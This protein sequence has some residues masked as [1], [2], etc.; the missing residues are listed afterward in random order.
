MKTFADEPWSVYYLRHDAI[1]ETDL[2]Q[3]EAKA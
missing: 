1:Y 3:T 2:S